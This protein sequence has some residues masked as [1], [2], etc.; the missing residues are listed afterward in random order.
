MYCFEK[1]KQIKILALCGLLGLSSLY[2]GTLFF[3]SEFFLSGCTLDLKRKLEKI[4]DQNPFLNFSLELSPEEKKEINKIVISQTKTYDKYGN[5]KD[6]KTE[7]PIFLESIGNSKELSSSVSSIIERIVNEIKAA[8]K[9]ETAW[10][11]IRSFTPTNEYDVPRLHTD[12]YYYSPR[13]GNQYKVAVTL[14][15]AG[16]LFYKLPSDAL[17]IF[18]EIQKGQTLENY[19]ENRVKLVKLLEQYPDNKSFV[20]QGKEYTGTVFI[21]GSESSAIHSEPPIHSERLFVSIL[22]GSKEQI[23]EWYDASHPKS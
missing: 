18:W 15:G 2:F 13:K 21:V 5:L 22:P 17:R 8:F 1:K 10:V 4:D 11:S 16:T 6:L 23:Q 3:K 12:G 19:T 14:N 7:V 20:H 9:A